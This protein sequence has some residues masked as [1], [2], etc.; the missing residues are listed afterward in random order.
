MIFMPT[1]ECATSGAT[2][3]AAD[4]GLPLRN[5]AEPPCAKNCHWLLAGI[6]HFALSFNFPQNNSVF[7][8]EVKIVWGEKGHRGAGVIQCP[9]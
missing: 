3:N 6:L 4:M 2:M 9:D 1:I 7:F 8:D 5:K